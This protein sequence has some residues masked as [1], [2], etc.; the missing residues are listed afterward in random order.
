MPTRSVRLTG[1][2][3]FF[4]SAGL[5]R[6]VTGIAVLAVSVFRLIG[7]AEDGQHPLDRHDEKL[8]VVLELD[9]NG[10]ARVEED[11]VVLAD[12]LVVIVFDGLGDGD[13]PAGNDGDFVAVGQDDAGF[14]FAFVVVLANDDALAD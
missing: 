10:L 2:R 7:A 6:I 14:G 13:N 4:T 5:L 12:G 11:L 8:V 1:T 3:P 9:G